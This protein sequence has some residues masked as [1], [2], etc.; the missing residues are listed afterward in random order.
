MSGQ[1][2]AENRGKQF[3]A[4]VKKAFEDVPN[5]SIIRLI[6]PQHGYA[7]VR[8]ICDF[9]VYHF[10][11][12]YFIE[13]KSCHG[14]VL[15][16]SNITDNQWSGLVEQSKIKGVKAGVLVWY[17][18]RDTTLFVPIQVLEQM[19]SEGA[20]SIRY[21]VDAEVIHID[22]KKKRVLFNYDMGAFFKEAQDDKQ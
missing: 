21:D 13:C 4:V 7:G 1:R 5:T 18:D 6:D 11:H 3:E 2:L 19:K 20:K 14:N 17:I 10:P 22:G 8:N 16:F 15:P 9:I 12:Q